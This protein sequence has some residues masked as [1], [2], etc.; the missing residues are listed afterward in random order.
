MEVATVPEQ[1]TSQLAI[2]VL[3]AC[4]DGIEFDL[5]FTPEFPPAY[6]EYS[7]SERPGQE[8]DLRRPQ[9]MAAK[10]VPSREDTSGWKDAILRLDPG[11]VIRW[12]PGE[13]SPLAAP[14]PADVVLDRQLP[15]LARA[16]GA[17]R[18][19]GAQR[20]EWLVCP[21]GRYPQPTGYEDVTHYS[22]FRVY[23][24]HE[25]EL[26]GGNEV[27]VSFEAFDHGRKSIE[28]IVFI[29]DSLLAHRSPADGIDQPP[30]IVVGGPGSGTG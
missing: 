4:R 18:G 26:D 11:N 28:L 2:N 10:P 22:R 1:S 27:A 8:R 14:S 29:Q 7:A 15:E 9:I 3:Q 25:L 5:M 20:W 19:S 21:S 24:D 17:V 23:W 6:E 13:T 16:W 12:K 30:V